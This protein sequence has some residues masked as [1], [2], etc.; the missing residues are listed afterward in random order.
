[1]FRRMAVIILLL[2]VALEEGIRFKY[3]DLTE[4]RILLTFWR[5]HALV[6]LAGAVAIY[7]HLTANDHP[8]LWPW[9]RKWR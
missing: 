1:M 8:I 6:M 4:T 3:P 9:W 5:V 2:C 7:L